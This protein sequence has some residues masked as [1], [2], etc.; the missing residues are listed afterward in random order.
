MYPTKYYRYLNLPS[1]PKTIIDELTLD[2]DRYREHGH[3]AGVYTW[4]DSF[5]E[6]IDKWCKEN[7]CNEMY[8]AFQ[9]ISGD[10]GIHKDKVT[11]IKFCYLI[12]P[13][14][15]NVVTEWYADDQTT[16]VD[17]VVFEPHR[18]AVLKVDEYHSVKNIEPGKTRFAITGRIF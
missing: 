17:S 9:I 2:F 8:W 18:W 1:I 7:I 11:Q 3:N 10:L 16:V 13:A 14:G 15:S 6:T 4:S 12:E 5:N